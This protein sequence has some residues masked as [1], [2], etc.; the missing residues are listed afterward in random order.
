MGF[1][2][3]SFALLFLFMT[4]PLLF[5]ISEAQNSPQDYL[6]AHNVARGQVG[7]P[8]ITW[9][10]TVATY[11]LNYVNSRTSDCNL[12]HSGGPYG[13][14]LAKGSGLFTGTAAVN[15]WVAEKPYYNYTS[16]SCVG[17]QQC[18]HYTQVVW[19]NSVRVGCARVQCNNGWWFVSCN[20]D[21]A[22][23]YIGQRPY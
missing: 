13:E 12:V 10:D 4:L 14:N 15:L 8:N 6:N 16:N 2:K 20:Y 1:S 11:A 5:Q 22:G 7:V 3:T 9:D 21:P 23:N 18:L 19:K 17:G